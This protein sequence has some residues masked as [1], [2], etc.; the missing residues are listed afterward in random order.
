MEVGIILG[1]LLAA[2]SII[3]LLKGIL[4]VQQS[5]C[6]IVERL[7]SFQKT[8][9]S[10]LNVIIPAVDQPRRIYWLNNGRVFVTSRLDLRETVLDVEK[11][12]VITRDN[13]SIEIDALLYIQ[14]VDP[15]KAAYEVSNLPMAVTQL[16][17]T[18]LR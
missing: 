15:T 14:I 13:V 16:T 11:Q 12:A 18:S 10:G 2:V 4:V 1:V 8:L 6:I 3:L 5:E 7:G 17:Q 9:K